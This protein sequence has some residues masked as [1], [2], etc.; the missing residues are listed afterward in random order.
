MTSPR[1]NM[2]S[3]SPIEQYQYRRLRIAALGATVAVALFACWIGGA[4]LWSPPQSIRVV[5]V[6]CSYEQN[7]MLPPNA[8]GWNTLDDLCQLGN[9]TRGRG[10]Y[11][12][13][14]YQCDDAPLRVTKQ[15]NWPS[16]LKNSGD[17]ALVLYVSMHGAGDSQ[18]PYLIPD[19]A[20]ELDP[21]SA[22]M[23]LEGL[24]QTLANL[25]AE[26]PKLV[27]FD[28]TTQ[29]GLWRQAV[30][31]NTFA[32]G[33]TT[34]EGHISQVPN[35]LVVCASS[36]GER[37]WIDQPQR[38]TSFG[39]H[40]LRALEG[41]ATDLNHDGRIT[42]HEA[43]EHAASRVD[44]WAQT[45]A[46]SSQRPLLLPATPAS[47]EQ[48]AAM[49]LAL[50]RSPNTEASVPPL[51][52]NWAASL[53]QQWQASA[54][55]HDK[56]QCPETVAPEA[57][58]QHI[59][60][61]LRFEEFTLAGQPAA[62]ERLR[63]KLQ[64]SQA[65]LDRLAT[66]HNQPWDILAGPQL[67]PQPA[68]DAQID[69][70]W[71]VPMAQLP[72][73]WAELSHNATVPADALRAR[74]HVRLLAHVLQSPNSSLAQAAELIR[75]SDDPMTPRPS[76]IHLV[77]MLDR[78]LPDTARTA[79]IDALV[80]SAIRC[81]IKAEHV[82][83][84]S[85]VSGL[86][87]SAV[88][89]WM[90]TSLLAL[91]NQRY[92]AEDL[93][94]AVPLNVEQATK[95]YAAIEQ[96]Y[97]DYRQR[98]QDVYEA[99]E[100]QRS[101][102]TALPRYTD[103]WADVWHDFDEPH[104][105]LRPTTDTLVDAWQQVYTLGELLREARHTA[106]PPVD[107]SVRSKLEQDIAAQV[108]T[109]RDQNAEVDSTFRKWQQSLDTKTGPVFW[110]NRAAMLRVP[111]IE[112][113]SRLRLLKATR[114]AS[115][116]AAT[117][118]TTTTKLVAAT[119]SEQAVV[120][121]ANMR[122]R[123]IAAA[124]S[125]QRL[126]ARGYLTPEAAQ[127]LEAIERGTTKSNSLDNCLS[128]AN[129]MAD[130]RGRSLRQLAATLTDLEN[131]PK[132]SLTTLTDVRN[133]W[134][135]IQATTTL[136]EKC[137]LASVIQK[138]SHSDACLLMAR[139]VLAGCWNGDS[140]GAAPYFQ[141]AAKA[142]LV[143][144]RTWTS[145]SNAADKLEP[146]TKN[147]WQFT[148][149]PPQ[150]Q[151]FDTV[152]L[153]GEA[154]PPI[155]LTLSASQAGG[156]KAYVWGTTGTGIASRSP[157]FGQRLTVPMTAAGA[158]TPC[159]L[160][161]ER[162][163]DSTSESFAPPSED[164]LTLH[165]FYRGHAVE[166]AVPVDIY[167]TPQYRETKSPL[168]AQASVAVV[169]EPLSNTAGVDEYG[170]V[171]V[172]DASGSMGPT[173]DGKSFKYQQAVD[174][175]AQLLKQV[176]DGVQVSVWVFGE[177]LGPH[178][179]VASPE[180]TIHR[181][182]RPTPWQASNTKWTSTLMDLLDDIE[183]WN[184]SPVT[185]AIVAAR[186]DLL[187]FPGGRAMVVLTDGQDS[188]ISQD[189]RT[190][191]T[192][193]WRRILQP[194]I[195]GT[196]ISLN[197]VTIGSTDNNGPVQQELTTVLDGLTPPGRWWNQQEVAALGQAL[198][199]AALRGRDIVLHP[200]QV[201][202]PRQQSV[203]ITR[204]L[205]GERLDPHQLAPGIYQ[206]GGRQ[207]LEVSPSQ[208]LLIQP[209]GGADG[210]TLRRVPIA[211]AGYPFAA[212]LTTPGGNATLLQHQTAENVPTELTVA[213]EPNDLGQGRELRVPPC[214]QVW[215]EYFASP[216]SEASQAIHWENSN[217]YPAATW[218]CLAGPASEASPSPLFPQV[219]V[220]WMPNATTTSPLRLQKG[221]EFVSA[222]QLAGTRCQLAG[223]DLHFVRAAVEQKSLPTANGS[224]APQH[225]LTMELSHPVGKL[226]R[227][228]LEGT[229]TAGGQHDYYPAI[230]RC[231][232]QFWPVDPDQLDQLVTG[233]A[234]VAIDQLKAEAESQGCYA[235]L[236]PMSPYIAGATPPS[237]VVDTTSAAAK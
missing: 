226:F 168:S 165:A 31:T 64:A 144:A 41:Y 111:T 52:A 43:F 161:V 60:L 117:R 122:L 148:I 228:Q 121:S 212:S 103:W 130:A 19:D 172:V 107:L 220:W 177:A 210:L 190:K 16:V 94:F 54:E 129:T 110:N 34:L 135:Q 42:A 213:V 200:Q 150:Q 67:E 18:G 10:F 105:D 98:L 132:T 11:R 203:S 149:Q 235:E 171:F 205:P 23:R 20:S 55:L 109:L 66:R 65:S 126:A 182:M 224:L 234:I 49:Q 225:C 179:T 115:G 87:V 2:A 116:D 51:D 195:A 1:T 90:E 92:A 157:A 3:P 74:L 124:Y 178:K 219:R 38:R 95:Q 215:L 29:R 125:P 93:L 76:T 101:V 145:H 164:T 194:A 72:A 100:L 147:A 120:E 191:Q 32:A 223:D 167:H 75:L 137:N 217:A 112:I 159:S 138:Q 227:V 57:W 185:S 56:L 59:D 209:F 174:V 4:C 146:L 193:D 9:R 99:V 83:D 201:S 181:L 189:A 68:I 192:D 175:L 211:R 176:P 162:L 151:T 85:H 198:R 28:V 86:H 133:W 206:V 158:S 208:F 70:L 79:E 62:A 96:Q 47:R 88:L 186:E 214:S 63:A 6:G 207:S 143:Q 154:S 187:A 163:D 229:S 139:R 15:F 204:T 21:A 231:T 202:S 102:A 119:S 169:S 8:F 13:Q 12:K 14:L 134:H 153:I 17:E 97:D 50:T 230:G 173:P 48:A 232:A 22:R 218:Q 184:E 188:Q 141:Q 170:I 73:K 123:L 127:Q 39:Y 37:S 136:A 24:F 91:D 128:E 77:A 25:P 156:G 166:V 183:P 33:L 84:P 30:P 118:K 89:P 26:Q 44:S 104:S 45:Q 233:V 35:L 106:T 82:L 180:Q 36:P 46:H 152:S 5:A 142:Y 222:T 197:V 113:E 221:I 108:S 78:Y 199:T 236:T 27:V 53:E 40:L 81:R 114:T 7:L 155:G 69:T 216:Q 196:D 71:R 160:V 131:S 58:A 237:P 80:A 61:L 140:P